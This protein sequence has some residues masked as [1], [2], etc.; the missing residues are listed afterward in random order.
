MKPYG[1]V[2]RGTTNPNRLRRVDA[3][4][5]D[6]LGHT[7]RTARDPVVVDLGYGATPVTAVELRTRLARVRQDVRVVGVEIDPVRVAG[8]QAY[9]QPPYLTF[10]RGG[11]ELAGLRPVVVRAMNVLRQYPLDAVAD[12]WS[13]MTARLADGGSVVEGTCDEPGRL[14]SWIRLTATGPASLTL[15]CRLSTLDSPGSLAERLPKALI[16]HNVPGQ[17]VYDFLS[18][19]DDA[20]RATAPYAPLGVRQRWVRSVARVAESWPVLD[21][22]NRWRVGEVTVAWAAVSAH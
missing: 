17:P 2:T 10:A 8:A 3:W 15:A 5:A 16:H 4:L 12:A 11:F 20:W 9:A 22:A 7:L 1:T 13:T 21:R 6:T 19:L 14:A 18:A